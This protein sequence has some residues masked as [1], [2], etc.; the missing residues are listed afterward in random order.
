MHF[1]VSTEHLEFFY[2]HHYIEFEALISES[3]AV[4]LRAACKGVVE[5]RL[6]SKETDNQARYMSGHDTWRDSAT[7]KKVV[8]SSHLAEIASQ[9]SKLR[10]L[11]IGYDQF[12]FAPHGA[13]FLTDPH[14]LE[15]Y[16]SLQGV[17]CGLMLQLEPLPEGHNHSNL[18]VEEDLTSLVPIPNKVGSGIFFAPHIPLSLETIPTDQLLIVYTESNALYRHAKN[19]PHKSY[20]REL[21]YSIGDRLENSTHPLVFRS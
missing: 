14:S 6:G 2:R 3:V 7:I 1:G 18:L 5:N 11:R 17:V 19:D 12:F 21:N 4:S 20:L 15:Q 10:Q 16:S 13:S 9:L 8:L